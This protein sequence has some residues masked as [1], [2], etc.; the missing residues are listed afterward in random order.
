MLITSLYASN[1][2]SQ[3][4]HVICGAQKQKKKKR[5]KKQMNQVAPVLQTP[6][7][8]PPANLSNTSL[9]VNA[10]LRGLKKKKKNIFI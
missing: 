10:F 9:L 3:Q 4:I 7:F 8:L 5:F 2:C 1:K 6:K